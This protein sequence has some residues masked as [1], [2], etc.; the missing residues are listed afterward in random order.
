MP[1]SLEVTRKLWSFLLLPKISDEDVDYKSTVY[2][3]FIDYALIC[4]LS[5]YFST[6]CRLSTRTTPASAGVFFFFFFF[7]FLTFSTV[8][9]IDC[10]ST[11]HR[12][13]LSFDY[14]LSTIGHIRVHIR[15]R[16]PTRTCAHPDAP[17][18]D[19]ARWYI[20]EADDPRRRW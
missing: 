7:F 19:R 18:H 1:P 14:R 4:R 20:I 2:R 11:S 15:M 6:I 12:L 5:I 3:L 13:Q 10:V 9:T 8:S 17:S 16:A